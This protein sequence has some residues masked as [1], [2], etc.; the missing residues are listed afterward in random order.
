M[1]TIKILAIDDE[2]AHLNLT[3][4]CLEDNEDISVEVAGSAS[5]ALAKIDSN[6]YDVVVSDY[7]MP[8]MDGLQLL[9]ELNERKCEVPFILFTG[10]G[11]EDIAVNALNLGASFYLQ[12][13][14]DPE[15]QYAEL[16]NMIRRSAETFRAKRLLIESEMK[17]RALAEAT[18][19]GIMFHDCGII[20]DCNLQFAHLFGYEPEEIIGKNGFD[21]MVSAE[22]RDEIL[23][24]LQMGAKG[25]ID[26]IGIKKDGTQICA[27]TSAFPIVRYGKPNICVQVYDITDRKS[28]ERKLEEAKSR[29]ELYTDLLTH[30]II[31][32]NTAAMGYLQLAEMR[33]PLDDKD[34]KLITRLLQVLENSS[35]LITIVRDLKMVETGKE[36]IV[37]IDIC[38]LLNEVK[39]VYEKHLDRAVTMTLDEDKNCLVMASGLLRDAFSNIVSNAIKHSSGPLTIGITV[40]K[41]SLEGTDLVRVIIADNGPGIPDERKDKIF[42]RSLMGLTKPVSRGLGLYLVKRLVENYHGSVWV[43]D[44][45]PMDHTQG[46]KFVVVLPAATTG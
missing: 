7:Q 3:K 40:N 21:F 25:R 28:L 45:V 11:R 31:N 14:S 12:K 34:G 19:E 36:E 42:D 13:G 22:T 35:E 9:K 41:L 32:Y 29:A 39:E 24:W 43:E 46:A 16:A 38:Q 44:R 18:T 33:L 5:E 4:I 1:D 20:I 10:K 15:A 26:F 2:P 8:R 37:E 6:E 17:F 23:R 27:E 30:D